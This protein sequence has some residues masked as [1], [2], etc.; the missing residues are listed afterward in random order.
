M[1]ANK[2]AMLNSPSSALVTE[3][4][5]L[6]TTIK[7]S[8]INESMAAL[9]IDSNNAAEGIK[10]LVT[11]LTESIKANG[12][13]GTVTDAA[14]SPSIIGS[15]IVGGLVTSLGGTLFRMLSGK[16]LGSLA[17]FTF[18]AAGSGAAGVNAAR[19]MMSFAGAGAGGAGAGGA[20]AGGAAAG[21][22]GAGGAAAGAAQTGS[23]FAS[24]L[25]W[26]PIVGDVAQGV[27]E[28]LETGSVGRGLFGG[29]GSFLG[30]LGLAAA[31]TATTGVGGILTQAAGGYA[32][33]NVGSGIYDWLF[34][35]TTP[36]TALQGSEIPTSS[37]ASL[38]SS[39]LNTI[40]VASN[41]TNVW[42]QTLTGFS[43]NIRDDISQI[44]SNGN[45]QNNEGLIDL[46]SSSSQ[47]SEAMI[48]L[49]AET[50][51]LLQR[52]IRR[53]DETANN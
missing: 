6:A 22:S 46:L 7:D 9:G 39:Y 12:L 27:S 14:M 20:G 5:T 30:R 44:K 4:E 47:N 15:V 18:G 53:Y 25:K 42:L 50:N 35:E 29:V 41:T 28:G 26:L 3:F 11:S 34:G 31:G 10:N 37:N 33:A 43:E 13:T 2:E 17:N 16:A 48:S 40:A 52:L 23:K 19:G 1:E 32:G 38:D 49:M 45:I 51:T 8:A 21:A 36:E 24:F